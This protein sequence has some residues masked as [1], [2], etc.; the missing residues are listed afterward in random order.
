VTGEW[1]FFVPGL[2]APGGSKKAFAF[3]GKDGKPH[4]NVT[5]AAGKRNKDWRAC[6]AL[7][8]TEHFAAPLPDA[9]CVDFLFVLP[10]P[11]GHFGS[12][13]NAA[14]LKANAPPH[15]MLAPDA[16]KLAR[17]TE[18]A[19]TKI[20]WADDAQVVDLRTR[21]QYGTR[22]G[23]HITIRYAPLPDDITP[24][25]PPHFPV[26][27]YEEPPCLTETPQDKQQR[28]LWELIVP[29]LTTS[30]AP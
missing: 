27:A 2:P 29:S 1:R 23:C 11:K 22:P 20:A 28:A 8:A 16:A 7:A 10:R 25:Q 13:R 19:L 4:A 14:V 3:V 12:G 30:K 18:D 6:V 15:H 17:S 26:L 24:P 5:D 21:K 9:I